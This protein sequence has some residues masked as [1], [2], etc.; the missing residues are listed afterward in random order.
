MPRNK[1]SDIVEGRI[2]GLLDLGYSQPQIMKILRHDGIQVSQP[3]ISNIKRKIGRQRNSNTKIKFL[4]KKP[5]QT[6]SI[7]K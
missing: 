1:I 6:S 2:L 7:V 5:S 4:R 3:T